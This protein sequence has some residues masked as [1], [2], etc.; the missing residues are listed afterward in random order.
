MV[1]YVIC[2]WCYKS[3]KH[4]ATTLDWY[5]FQNFSPCDFYY[6]VY[7]LQQHINDTLAIYKYQ[8]LEEDI[9]IVEHNSGQFIEFQPNQPE[10]FHKVADGNWVKWC[11]TD[12]CC[13]S[14]WC[15]DG[16]RR[17]FQL[18]LLRS[19]CLSWSPFQNVPPRKEKFWVLKHTILA[20]KKKVPIPPKLSQGS[21]LIIRGKLRKH[22]LF[23][24][25]VFLA[26]TKKETFSPK[27]SKMSHRV[28]KGTLGL[29]WGY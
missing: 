18:Y 3:S 29:H 15:Q 21:F 2:Q 17:A 27:R 7:L 1:D 5:I 13:W 8:I 9:H 4:L 25:Y 6:L 11:L 19:S 24:N 28:V 26:P 20:T 16:E 23:P 12:N 22:N 10:E 14:R